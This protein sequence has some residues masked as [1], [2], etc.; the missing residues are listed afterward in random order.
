MDNGDPRYGAIWE[1][2]PL[3]VTHTRPIIV[4]NGDKQN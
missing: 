2:A 3:A 4:F 1:R